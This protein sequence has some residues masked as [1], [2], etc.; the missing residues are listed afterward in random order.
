MANVTIELSVGDQDDLIEAIASRVH[1]LHYD[2]LCSA[3]GKKMPGEI[4]ALVDELCREPIKAELDKVL[5]EGSQAVGYHGAPEGD[6]VSLKDQV[7]AML[8][9]AKTDS[10]GNKTRSLMDRA[11]GRKLDEVLKT[12]FEPE[13]NAARVKFSNELVRT[14]KEKKR[15]A[16]KGVFGIE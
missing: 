10:W 1:R 8:F 16:L 15:E 4:K 6:R 7:S 2:D 3:A 11:I 9:E 13:I 12:M 5:S 14:F